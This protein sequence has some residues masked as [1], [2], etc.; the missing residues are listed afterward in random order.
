[1]QFLCGH[2]CVYCTNVTKMPLLVHVQALQSKITSQSQRLGVFG[3]MLGD[4]AAEVT[5]M[6][7]Q[8]FGDIS[9]PSAL[10]SA[11]GTSG[12]DRSAAGLLSTFRGSFHTAS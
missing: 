10:T 5:A 12:T 4:K 9:L 11:L 8:S 1:M 3:S 7:Q 2:P 6:A